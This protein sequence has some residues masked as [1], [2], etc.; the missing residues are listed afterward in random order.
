MYKVYWTES[1]QL[2]G[3][4]YGSTEMSTALGKTQE[5][6]QRQHTGDDVHFITMVSENPDSVGRPGYDVTGPDYDW[7]KRR[8]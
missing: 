8:I 3:V 5:L 6:Y 4:E 2:C 1:G 7:K